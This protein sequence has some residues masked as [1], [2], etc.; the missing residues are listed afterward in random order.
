MTILD[1][2]KPFPIHC[3]NVPGDEWLTHEGGDKAFQ[4]GPTF[5]QKAVAGARALAKKAGKGWTGYVHYNL[6]W[7]F[8]A[9]SPK[10]NICLYENHSS[11]STLFTKGSQFVGRGRTPK[12]ACK[13]I[14]DQMKKDIADQQSK[15]EAI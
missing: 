8:S 3:D 9:R 4:G 11:Y 2:D 6:G 1:A 13:S 12:A 10:G 7:H 5:F 15:L 14:L